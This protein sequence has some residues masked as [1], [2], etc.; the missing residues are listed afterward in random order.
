MP[1]K[2]VIREFGGSE[3]LE[4]SKFS[5]Q[6]PNL[7]EVT[8]EH[9]AIGLN[10]ID[11]YQRTG[12]YPLELPTALGVEASGVVTEIGDSVAHLKVG[13]RVAY[14][15]ARP[16]AYSDR[17]NL[18]ATQVC[19]LP[20]DVSFKVGAAVMLKGLTVQYL[21]HRTTPLNRGDTVLLHAAAGGVGLIA[22]QWARSEAVSYTH[23][24]LPT[25]A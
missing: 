19:K 6:A 5:L 4:L 12:L 20:E 18:D 17:R 24:T 22:C 2:V 9:R 13:D 1:T 10:Y 14:A 25:K 7:D 16:G 21:F 3:N 8:V 15:S 11:I 23:L